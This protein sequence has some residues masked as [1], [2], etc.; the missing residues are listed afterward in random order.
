MKSKEAFSHRIR[1]DALMLLIAIIWGSAFSAQQMASKTVGPFMVLGLRFS[2]AALLLLCLTRFRIELP[3]KYFWKTVL[4]GCLLFSASAFQ[5]IALSI[6]TVG[7]AGFITGMY[8]IFIPI[9]LWLVWQEKF[10]WNVWVSVA[11]VVIGLYLLTNSGST[12]FGL[13][14][15]FLLI[16]AILYALQMITLSDIVRNANPL[17]VAVVQFLISGAAGLFIGVLFEDN[18]WQNI[19]LAWMPLVY[20]TVFSTTIAYTL[21]GVAQKTANPTDAAIFL[22]MESVFAAIFGVIFLEE[23]F[24]DLQIAGAILMFASMILSQLTFNSKRNPTRGE[25]RS[26]FE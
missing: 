1:L 19:Q 5:Q 23:R 26:V 21:Q 10:R 12:T 6:S 18:S 3:R 13:G 24:S 14:D 2:G 22:S 8:V 25:A 17:H 11:L 4:A 7:N 15:L 20:I 16:C 9:F